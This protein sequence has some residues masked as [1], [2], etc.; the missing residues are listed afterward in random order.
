MRYDSN[1]QGVSIRCASAFL[2]VALAACSVDDPTGP[3]PAAQRAHSAMAAETAEQLQASAAALSNRFA[4][5]WAD[6]PTAA[7]Y[8]P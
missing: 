4:N 3:T 2:A 1:A 8:T 5:V 6:Q 7:S